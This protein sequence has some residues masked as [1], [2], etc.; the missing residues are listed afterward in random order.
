M[1]PTAGDLVRQ[2]GEAGNRVAVVHG[3]LWPANLLVE[4]CGECPPT[5]PASPDGRVC[6][7]DTPLIDLAHLVTHMSGWS[8]ARAEDVLAAYTDAAPLSPVERR[9]LPVVAAVDLLPTVGDLLI[10]AFVDEGVA[11]HEAQ[12]V[13]GAA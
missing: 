13:L 5:R 3:D 8:G 9:L 12:P 7:V 11:D 10:L 6:K 1:V 4:G 2:A